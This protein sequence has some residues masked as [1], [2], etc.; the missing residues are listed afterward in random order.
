MVGSQLSGTAR[1]FIG[2]LVLL[3]IITAVWI[4]VKIASIVIMVLAVGMAYEFS[5]MLKTPVIMAVVLILLMALQSLPVWVFDAGVAW[6]SGLA[7]VSSG[8]IMRYRGALAGLFAIA[9][10]ICLYFSTLLLNQTNGHLLL[11]LLA[12]VVAACDCAAYFVGRS[13]GG[14]KLA[15]SVSPNKTVSGSIGGIVAAIAAMVVLSGIP[16]LATITGLGPVTGLDA[17]VALFLGCGIAVLSQ[18]GD[19]LESALKRRLNVK[20]S[21]SILPGHGGL[22]DRFDGYLFTVPGFYLFFFVI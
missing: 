21:G 4:D 6:H 7:A 19:L 17:T 3:P 5:K 20:D 14:V 15:P 13:V 9:L 10:S 8:I 22:L 11:L 1:R 12:A 18:I 2:G 16:A